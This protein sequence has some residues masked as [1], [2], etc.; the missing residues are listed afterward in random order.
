MG[1]DNSLSP[2]E[3]SRYSRHIRLPQVGVEGQERLRRARVLVIGMGGLGSP[4][5]LY[6]AAG[7]VGTLGLADFD[8]VEEHN[9]Q[10]Q[11]LHT[12]AAVGHA[13]IDSAAERLRALNRGCNL[14]LHRG[15]IT[16]DNAVELISQYDLVVDGSDNFPTRYLVNDA[17]YFARRPLVYGSIFQFEGQVSVFDPHTGG[18]CYR[19]LFP[20]IP[21]PGTV[22]N[23][24]QAGVFGALCGIVGSHQAMEALKL[25]LGIGE[26]LRGR[27]LVVDALNAR[28][29]TL[30]LKKDPHCPLC[31]SE[32][33]ISGLH[34]GNYEFSCETD[35]E[36]QT[37]EAQMEIDIHTAQ[38]RHT[39]GDAPVLLDVREGFEREICHIP[40]SSHIPLGQLPAQA[41]ALPRDAEIIVYCHHGARSLRAAKF[42]RERGF[43]KAISMAGGIDQWAREI[44]PSMTRY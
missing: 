14:E 5:S 24:E 28:F 16:L 35:K 7:G 37:E 17:A 44:D 8:K 29:P 12:Q 22:P 30:N 43:D 10:R 41:D 6:L 40:G 15:G 38:A 25:L 36:P 21:E 19:C 3:L 2:E 13:K 31:G 11:V 39:S 1:N 4:V 34:P 20:Q 18:P 27:L 42:L 9:L 26:S 33:S 23:C 32:P